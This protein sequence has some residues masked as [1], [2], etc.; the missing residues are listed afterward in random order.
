MIAAN[1]YEA[2]PRLSRNWL[3][4]RLR[5]RSR[6]G[7]KTPARPVRSRPA[8][9]GKQPQ[10]EQQPDAEDC[11]GAKQ[12]IESFLR[13]HVLNSNALLYAD[14]RSLH[15]CRRQGVDE[16]PSDLVNK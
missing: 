1:G 6:S 12:D 15:H 2:R 8:G 13:P 9:S 16:Y 11:G 7:V 5:V 14:R 10:A 4:A 3:R